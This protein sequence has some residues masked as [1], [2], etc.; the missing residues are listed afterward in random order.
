MRAVIADDED[1]PRGEL[2]RL[3][4]KLWPTLEIIA[5]VDSGTAVLAV[6]QEQQPDIAFLDIHMPGLNGLQVAEQ[7]SD[8]LQIVFVTSFDQYA[9][10]AFEKNAVDYLLKPINPERLS[11]TIAKLQKAP[12][13]DRELVAKALESIKTSLQTITPQ[14]LEWIKALKGDT[15]YMI[16]VNDITHLQA[17]TKYT[18]AFTLDDEFQI[19]T[20]LA[21][22]EELLDAA[23]FWRIHRSTIVNAA[24]IKSAKRTR[25]GRYALTLKHQGI[26]L[27]VSRAYAHHFKHI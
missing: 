6:I 15:V 16:H 20:P 22:L 26:K 1:L 21:Q 14:R 18:T 23:H 4:R 13:K 3:L 27:D 10:E 11:Q 7:M 5:S 19:R 2:E 25:D 17:D 12:S 9:V 8:H 24:F